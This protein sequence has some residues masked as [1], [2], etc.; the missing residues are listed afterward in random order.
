MR[1]SVIREGLYVL[2]VGSLLFAGL[3][4]TSHGSPGDLAFTGVAVGIALSRAFYSG[5]EKI[6]AWRASEAYRTRP[7]PGGPTS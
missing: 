1:S 2:L 6:R 4:G 3:W 7:R 5:R